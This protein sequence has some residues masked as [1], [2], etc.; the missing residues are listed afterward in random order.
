MLTSERCL[1]LPE[2]VDKVVTF[3][4]KNDQ[5][6]CLCINSAW[7][8]LALPH[9]FDSVLS[10]SRS[11]E[12][13]IGDLLNQPH[14]QEA[15]MRNSGHIRN[16]YTGTSGL[17][18]VLI[19]APHCTNLVSLECNLSV[20][21]K[22]VIEMLGPF[23]RKNPYLSSVELFGLPYTI[24]LEQLVQALQSCPGLTRLQ[25]EYRFEHGVN[26]RALAS[27]IRG[28]A[29]PHLRLKDLHLDMLLNAPDQGLVLFEAG[30]ENSSP[31][32]PDLTLFI[33]HDSGLYSQRSAEVFYLPML[34]EAPELTCLFL[35][36]MSDSLTAAAAAAIVTQKPPLEEIF[37]GSEKSHPGFVDIIKT[38]RR[39]LRTL[40]AEDTICCEPMLRQI[41]PTNNDATN[42]CLH[43]NLQH[44]KIVLKESPTVSALI[45]KI[46]TSLSSLKCF[47]LL[48]TYPPS[49]N[50]HSA[51]LQI[52]DMVATPWA[53]VGIQ[54]LCLFLGSHSA[55]EDETETQKGRRAKI[56]QVYKQLGVLTQLKRLKLACDVLG[57]QSEVELDFTLESGVQAMEPCMK[58]L[59]CLDIRDVAGSR[60][61]QSEREWVLQH[62]PQ[63]QSNGLLSVWQY[64]E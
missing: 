59:T 46:L 9:I 53:C 12:R 35:P 43:T 28:L 41:L 3:L 4:D 39:T 40:D 33:F 11:F 62:G 55:Y 52:R 51:R 16:V 36:K 64:D 45:Q 26:S 47:M 49:V 20:S 32:F 50:Q 37:F 54:E 2:M 31:L 13:C 34:R 57:G 6:K 56:G 38:T 18:P 21:A 60:I 27:L 24:N 48:W 17:L 1:M 23:I 42:L 19:A 25:L 63:L 29:Y 44:I 58:S 7:R 30:C 10:Y 5:I 61:S 14:A 15:L 22:E 8:D